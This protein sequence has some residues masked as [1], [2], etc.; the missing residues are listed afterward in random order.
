MRKCSIEGCENKHHGRG[1]CKKHYNKIILPKLYEGIEC[2][3]EGCSEKKSLY[4]GKLNLCEK[5]FTRYKRYG[6]VNIQKRTRDYKSLIEE[7]KSID[8]DIFEYDFNLY[9]WRILCLIYYGDICSECGWNEG[10]CETHHIIFASNGGKNSIN[11]CK[12]LCPNCHSLIHRNKR[13]RFT[14]EREKEIRKLLTED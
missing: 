7:I 6:D 14:E 10:G 13:K 3:V 1:Y 2:E 4:S 11:N 9:T 12:V 5:H 8:G